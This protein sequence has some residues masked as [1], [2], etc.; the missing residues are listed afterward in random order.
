MIAFTATKETEWSP[1]FHNAVIGAAAAKARF[2]GITS[3]KQKCCTMLEHQLS[4]S[5]AAV[6]MV[7]ANVRYGPF[8]SLATAKIGRMLRCIRCRLGAD[9]VEK[10]SVSP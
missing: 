7:P 2:L 9:C 8:V 10:L 6:S 4:G 1:G 5:C 3:M